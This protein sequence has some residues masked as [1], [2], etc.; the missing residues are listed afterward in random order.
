MRRDQ[1]TLWNAPGVLVLFAVL[2]GLEWW[3]RRRW[4]ML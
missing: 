3:Y 2:L 4:D 1:V